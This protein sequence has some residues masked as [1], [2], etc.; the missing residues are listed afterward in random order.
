MSNSLS[1]LWTIVQF[2]FVH[3]FPETVHNAQGL[4][5]NPCYGHLS[6]FGSKTSIFPFFDNLRV[7]I[8]ESNIKTLKTGFNWKTHLGGK[9]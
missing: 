7:Y 3:G 8:P 1:C 6:L 9:R 2:E 4:N 5:G